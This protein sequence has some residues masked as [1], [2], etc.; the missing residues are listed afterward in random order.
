MKSTQAYVYE[1]YINEYKYQHNYK[2]LIKDLDSD[3]ILEEDQNETSIINKNKLVVIKSTN[4]FIGLY[5]ES[6]Y[7]VQ[8]EYSIEHNNS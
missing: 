4:D 2:L 5:F 6:E 3:T 8:V 7:Q 1:S